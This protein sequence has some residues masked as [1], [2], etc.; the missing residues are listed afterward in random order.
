MV[1][2]SVAQVGVSI[3]MSYI[4][5]QGNCFGT[6]FESVK[7]SRARFKYGLRF[8]KQHKTQLIS[9]TLATKLQEGRPD[10]F[11]K[12]VNRINNCK[13]PLPNGIDGVTGADNITELWKGHFEQLFNCIHDNDITSFH[14]DVTYTNYIFGTDDEI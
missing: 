5:W 2:L 12:E 10:R 3:L 14:Y 9:N 11:W 1:L 6:V 4:M 7:L 8:L 13:V